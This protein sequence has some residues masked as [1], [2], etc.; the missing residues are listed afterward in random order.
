MQQIMSGN[1]SIKKEG[2]NIMAITPP[3]FQKDAIPTPQGC[4]HPKTGELLVARKISIEDIDEYNNPQ[5]MTEW[6]REPVDDVIYEE[7]EDWDGDDIDWEDEE[8][9]DLDLDSMTKAE[10]IETAEDWEI[11]IDPKSTKAKIKEILENELYDDEL[12]EDDAF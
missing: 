1:L 5:T 4:R 11:E 2:K 10:L 8:L 3:S 12:I 6:I 9:E 7:D